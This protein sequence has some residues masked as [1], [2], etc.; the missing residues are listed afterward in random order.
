MTNEHGSSNEF[1]LPPPSLSS[2]KKRETVSIDDLNLPRSVVLRLVKK[3]L[4]EH[5]SIQKDAITALI[6]GSSVFINYLSAAAFDLSKLSS[7]KVILPS[8]VLKAI[9]NIEFSS[10]IPRM[11]GELELYEEILKEKKNGIELNKDSSIIVETKDEHI[12]KKL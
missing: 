9:E 2:K 7:R 12:I 10:F 4:P 3:V 6:R 8:D 5:T 1:H 11:T